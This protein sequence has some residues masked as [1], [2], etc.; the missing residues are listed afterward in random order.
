MKLSTRLALIVGS[1]MAGL[2]LIS[3]VALVGIRSTMMAERENQ[4]ATLLDL[5]KGELNYLYEQEQAGKLSRAEAQEK[6]AEALGH[7]R[8]GNNY[9]LA[10]NDEDV[11]VIHPDKARM[12]KLDKGTLTPAGKYPADL[13]RE[14]LAKNDPAFVTI[15]AAKPGGDKK[16]LFD[17]LNGVSRFSPW[18]WTVGTGFFVD[19]IDAAFRRYAL[20][21]IVAGLVILALTATLAVVFSKRIYAQLG[22]E[23][24]V[25]MRAAGAIAAGD[26]S[27]HLPDAKSGSLMAALKHMQQS[28]TQMIGSIQRSSSALDQASSTIAQTMGEIRHASAQSSEATSSTAAAIEEMTVSV[29]QI[30]DSARETQQNSGRATELAKTG[31]QRVMAASQAIHAV[32]AQVDEASGR[33]GE[34]ADRSRQIDGIASTIKEIAEQTNLLALNAAIEAARAGEQGRGFAVVADEVRKLAERTTKAT[35]EIAVTISAIQTDT[36]MVVTSMQ[37]VKPQVEKG[38]NL[39]GEA[40]DALR[41][42]LEGTYE[43]LEK[44]SEVAHA[45]SEQTAASN[46]I[47]GNI[48]RIARMV[49]DSDQAVHNADGAAR[50][51]SSLASELNS[52]VSRFRV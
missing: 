8:H 48:E 34:L 12:G 40:A 19:D 23:P 2:I 14:G 4:I 36:D 45:T 28:L 30:A 25:A 32:S 43:T 41:S 26:L 35:Q 15:Q 38:V 7:F 16:V 24:E 6:A 47:A 13:Y 5:A 17:K 11:L 18:S 50:S 20:T 39:A 51:L 22:G 37:A 42:I 21:L 31:E 46:S 1:S 10:R 44:I 33:I 3:C 49:E 52:T 27:Q 9:I 29:G